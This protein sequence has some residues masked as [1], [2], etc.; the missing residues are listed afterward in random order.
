MEFQRILFLIHRRKGHQISTLFWFNTGNFRW[1][2]PFD[3]KFWLESIITNYLK[4]T[5]I[6]TEFFVCAA[7]VRIHTAYQNCPRNYYAIPRQKFRTCCWNHPSYLTVLTTLQPQITT[8]T[9][10]VMYYSTDICDLCS[11]SIYCHRLSLRTALQAQKLCSS[12]VSTDQLWSM[13]YFDPWC[14]ST[15]NRR[16]R[17]RYEVVDVGQRWVCWATDTCLHSSIP[18]Y[19]IQRWSVLFNA[20]RHYSEL[21]VALFVG[22]VIDTEES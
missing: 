5:A 2:N 12:I 13:M 6:T 3:F 11:T 19:V 18:G 20:L 4:N 16:R 17:R 8:S 14:I 7:P 10:T 9:T 21:F 1:A 15:M 22:G